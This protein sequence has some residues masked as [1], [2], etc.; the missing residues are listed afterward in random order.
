M[1]KQQEPVLQ[2][3]L[4]TAVNQVV[5][6]I[7]HVLGKYT[8]SKDDSIIVNSVVEL[9]CSVFN[10]LCSQQQLN[11]QDIVAALEITNRPV[12]VRLSLSVL[13]Y[14]KD[15]N[16]KAT[17]LLN[18][19]CYQREKINNSKGKNNLKRP[20]VYIYLLNINTNHFILL[21]INK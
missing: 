1:F 5:E 21:K 12:I 8:L 13:L 17:P 16:S 7:G 19:L 4:D 11:C 2:G 14:K 10:R 3:C 15:V 6:G 9:S 20:Q 18:P